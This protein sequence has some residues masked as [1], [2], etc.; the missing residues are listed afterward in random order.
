MVA[1]H[2]Y[3]RDVLFRER[4]DVAGLQY[5]VAI[6]DD[7]HVYPEDTVFALPP[8]PP[9]RGRPATV[10]RADRP[11]ASVKTVAASV[12]DDDWQQIERATQAGKKRLSQVS[13]HRVFV[14]SRVGRHGLEPRLEWL[15]IE[16]R[17]DRTDYWLSN[18]PAGTTVTELVR[19]AHLRWQI[20]LDYKELKD[21]LGLDHYEGRSYSG[22]HHHAALISA[23]HAFLTEER[24]LRPRP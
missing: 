21:E 12:A 8:P 13:C 9:G 24:R 22:W 3:G 16:K 5:M 19:I 14:A 23:A 11:S 15:I 6:D 10:V 1:D 18:L 17:P 2:F 7:T 20:E 4:L